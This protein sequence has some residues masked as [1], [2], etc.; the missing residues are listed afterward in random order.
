M[1]RVGR[2]G[3]AH[4][5]DK[6]GIADN[7]GA[8]G[9]ATQRSGPAVPDPVA[10]NGLWALARRQPMDPKKAATFGL[11]ADLVGNEG[12]DGT[13]TRTTSPH[14][15]QPSV[16]QTPFGRLRL[17]AARSEFVD[18]LPREAKRAL[19]L[20]RTVEVIEGP[21]TEQC[22]ERTTWSLQVPSRPAVK[23]RK[24]DRT[25]EL[26][27]NDS[28]A[29]HF[30]EGVP[31]SFDDAVRVEPR[32]IVGIAGDGGRE[33]FS[34]LSDDEAAIFGTDAAVE[35]VQGA[36]TIGQKTESRFRLSSIPG[37]PFRK[38]HVGETTQIAEFP[39]SRDYL[40][41]TTRVRKLSFVQVPERPGRKVKLFTSTRTRRSEPQ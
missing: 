16:I 21:S 22:V 2:W 34:R 37:I 4:R 26:P 13:V 30:K 6:A 36:I 11:N 31:M 17:R 12:T 3:G 8:A 41:G 28:A 25:W 40:P 29:L 35:N 1:F 38:M 5:P 15:I 24:R 32:S 14:W 10:F 7:G 9:I 39:P 18:M 27:S 20:V 33:R 23:W 19:V